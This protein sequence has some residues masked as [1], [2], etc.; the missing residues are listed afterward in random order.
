MFR[1]HLL[2]IAI[3]TIMV[4]GCISLEEPQPTD[5]TSPTTTTASRSGASNG[6]SAGSGTMTGK[7]TT[8]TAT[9]PCSLDATDSLVAIG[10]VCATKTHWLEGDLS[11]AA[12]A[13]QLTS[14]NGNV[15]VQGG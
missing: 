14:F 11:L 7:E 9:S 1:T 8:A 12:L 10:A 6:A 13:I 2:T 3:A 4:S 15:D 5:T